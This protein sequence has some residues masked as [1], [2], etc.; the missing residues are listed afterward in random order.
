MK[1]GLAIALTAVMLVVV[2]VFATTHR[3]E[4]CTHQHNFYSTQIMSQGRHCRGTVGCDCPGFQP[5]M[6]GDVWQQAYCR[7]CGHMRKFH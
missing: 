3:E 2:S 4:C 7:N 1:K 5:I 6:N